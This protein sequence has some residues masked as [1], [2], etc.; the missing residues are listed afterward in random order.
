MN[1]LDNINVSKE[2]NFLSV[3]NCEEASKVTML[4]KNQSR[5]FTGQTTEWMKKWINNEI[6]PN[7]NGT[8]NKAVLIE[9]DINNEII[10]ILCVATYNHESEKGPMVWIREIAVNPRFQNKG[11]GRK[12][13]LQALSY[14]KSYNSKRAFIVADEYNAPGIHLYTSIGFT[15][16]DEESQID[17]LK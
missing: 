8:R 17:M 15:P 6:S 7:N 14:G 5:G 12:L 1:N 9:R 13:I 3:E 10:G 11:I 2:F 16:S 4:C